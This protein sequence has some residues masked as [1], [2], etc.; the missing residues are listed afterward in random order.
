VV[1]KNEE[2][3]KME[4]IQEMMIDQLGMNWAGVLCITLCGTMPS[5]PPGTASYGAVQWF[6]SSFLHSLRP[7][8]LLK[9][10]AKCQLDIIGP[11]SATFSPKQPIELYDKSLGNKSTEVYIMIYP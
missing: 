11:D 2:A 7:S 4:G 1:E 5:D 8:K 6:D 3:G 10:K 9:L